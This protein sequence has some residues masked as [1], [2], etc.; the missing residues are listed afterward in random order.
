MGFPCHLTL[1]VSH[2]F[3][4]VS[5]VLPHQSLISSILSR[6]SPTHLFSHDPLSVGQV[7]L[8]EPLPE[9]ALHVCLVIYSRPAVDVPFKNFLCLNVMHCYLL[10]F[11]F[12]QLSLLLYQSKCFTC[13]IKMRREFCFNGFGIKCS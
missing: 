6:S 3:Y 8:F 7:S 12:Q 11:L 4:R 2:I 1:G 5:P 10:S 13:Q 9:V